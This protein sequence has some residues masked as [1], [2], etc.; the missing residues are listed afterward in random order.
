[1]YGTLT[2]YGVSK[3]AE[4]I[5]RNAIMYNNGSKPIIFNGVQIK[6]KKMKLLLLTILV[7]NA[8]CLSAQNKSD[9][10]VI[11]THFQIDRV[12]ER[13]KKVLVFADSI[14]NYKGGDVPHFLYNECFD[15]NAPLWRGFHSNVSLRW[16]V[17][18]MVNNKNALKILLKS[19]DKKLGKKC[20]LVDTYDQENGIPLINKSFLDLIRK[21]YRQI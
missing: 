15:F 20:S 6:I 19:H 5:G 12:K 8:Y 21:R 1:V 16:Q 10:T 3:A 7:F 18:E 17:L 14:N 4:A 9:S 11:I 2:G 13:E